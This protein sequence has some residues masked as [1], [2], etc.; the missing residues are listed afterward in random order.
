MEAHTCNPSPWEVELDLEI[1]GLPWIQNQP[2]TPA[3]AETYLKK[4]SKSLL[5]AGINSEI[6]IIF[7][8]PNL[9]R[10]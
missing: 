6:C 1:Q 10:P 4:T 9:H 7:L 3:W 2:K 8:T 5:K